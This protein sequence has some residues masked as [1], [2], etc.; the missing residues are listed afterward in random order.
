[1]EILFQ[2]YM[3]SFLPP[4]LLF[5]PQIMNLSSFKSVDVK[6]VWQE[7]LQSKLF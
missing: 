4:T 5:P 7:L 2:S 3:D 6:I 1:M